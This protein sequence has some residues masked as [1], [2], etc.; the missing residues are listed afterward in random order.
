M[1]IRK[2][3]SSPRLP[4]VMIIVAT[5]TTFYFALKLENF[6]KQY[7]S[8]AGNSSCLSLLLLFQPLVGCN[9]IIVVLWLANRYQN[10]RE[11]ERFDR[12]VGGERVEHYS[13]TW[14]GR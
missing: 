14:A 7:L 3:L 4:F 11:R 8:R 1:A 6:C 12:F 9:G 10:M 5:V 13:N 2:F